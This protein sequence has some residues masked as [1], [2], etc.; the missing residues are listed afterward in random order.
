MFGG[1]SVEHASIIIIPP[2][3][4]MNLQLQ[5]CHQTP[6]TQAVILW[7]RLDATVCF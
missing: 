6:G 7:T 5:R 2:H 1:D 4:P 3:V